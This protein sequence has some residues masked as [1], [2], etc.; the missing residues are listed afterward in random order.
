MIRRIA[1]LNFGGVF[2]LIGLLGGM[3]IVATSVT[4]VDAQD[5]PETL[6]ATFEKKVFANQSAD[7]TDLNYRLFRPQNVVPGQSYPLVVFLH[8]AG[9]RGSDNQAQLKHSVHEFVRPERQQKYP[10]FVIAP[11]CP[12]DAK[13]VEIDWSQKSGEGSFDT[14]TSPI[15][16]S[17][18]QLIDVMLDS[19]PIDSA[20]VYFAG[21][22]MGGYGSWYA[23]AKWP[24]KIAAVIPVCG[25][26]DPSWADRYN[27]VAIWALHGQVD[28]AVPVVRSRE[29]V[30]AIA[31][32]GHAPEVRYTEYPGVDHDSW[33]QTF[34]RD[35]V[36][37][38][39]FAQHR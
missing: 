17:V 9:E 12:K 29:M 3:L 8:G 33:T 6:R 14:A 4:R 22:S 28:R 15:V 31:R 5:S 1:R 23:A 26:G 27:G 25:G 10:C 35:D 38:W 21:L 20:R 30:S 19:E 37:A 34:V 13:W 39:L 24:Q 7:A 11:Q 16:D 36:F 18:V 32:V 2:V